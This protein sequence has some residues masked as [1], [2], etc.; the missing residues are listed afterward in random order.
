MITA[1][2]PATNPEPNWIELDLD[3]VHIGR[4]WAHAVEAKLENTLHQFMLT[5]SGQNGAIEAFIWADAIKQEE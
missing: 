1:V 5:V 2:L 4:V 3:G